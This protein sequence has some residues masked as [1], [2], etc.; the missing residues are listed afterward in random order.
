MTTRACCGSLRLRFEYWPVI[1]LWPISLVL[2]QATLLEVG[3]FSIT[4]AVIACHL[5]QLHLVMLYWLNR[6][7]HWQITIALIILAVGLGAGALPAMCRNSC[8]ASRTSPI[9]S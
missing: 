6:P 1:W 9:P 8:A 4:V 7:P 5:L 3:G 2:M